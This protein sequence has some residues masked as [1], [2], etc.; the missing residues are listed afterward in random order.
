[1]DKPVRILVWGLRM[2]G[3]TTLINDIKSRISAADTANR[4]VFT[5]SNT[6]CNGDGTG[7]DLTVYVRPTIGYRVT[8]AISADQLFAL[9]DTAC[10]NYHDKCDI[11][12]SNIPASDQVVDMIVNWIQ[13]KLQPKR[14][15][16]AT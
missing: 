10:E 8:R 15:L 1:M 7:Y 13:S 4:V 14:N 2:S 16:R 12:I 5:E 9:Q 3:K 6:H 11:C